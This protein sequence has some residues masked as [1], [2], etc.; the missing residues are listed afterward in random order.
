MAAMV[1]RERSIEENRGRWEAWKAAK[2]DLTHSGEG[3]RK[4]AEVI[5]RSNR[6]EPRR[7]V[8][9]SDDARSIAYGRVATRIAPCAPRSKPVGQ[10]VLES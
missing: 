1:R 2:I 8:R 3:S 10:R 9:L 7:R 5:A 4:R 6:L